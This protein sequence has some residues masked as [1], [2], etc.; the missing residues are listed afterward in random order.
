M[1]YYYNIGKNK[2]LF[3]ASHGHFA[4][5]DLIELMKKAEES[6]HPNLFSDREHDQAWTGKNHLA[7]LKGTTVILPNG[8]EEITKKIIRQKVTATRKDLLC[9]CGKHM[10]FLGYAVWTETIKSEGKEMF[11]VLGSPVYKDRKIQRSSNRYFKKKSA[12]MS[13]VKGKAAA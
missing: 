10:V 11:K 3:Y 7:Y 4:C 9:K 5:P 1:S 2:K 12:Q 13:Y 6:E 8:D